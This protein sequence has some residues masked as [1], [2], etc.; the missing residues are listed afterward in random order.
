MTAKAMPPM[1]LPS[2]FESR[3]DQRQ[4]RVLAGEDDDRRNHHTDNAFADDQAGREQH[5]K[6]LGVASGLGR[7]I[8]APIKEPASNRAD[9]NHQRALRRQINPE[10]H[11]K[12]RNAHVFCRAR[13][14]LVQENDADADQCRRFGS[15]SNRCRAAIT[16]CASEEIRPA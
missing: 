16:P 11:C 4:R 6:L 12:R 14:N 8:C 5:A 7:A 15:G 10:A 13:E 3:A 2:E 9:D 1:I